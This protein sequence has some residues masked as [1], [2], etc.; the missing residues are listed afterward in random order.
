[1]AIMKPTVS[2][3]SQARCESALLFHISISRRQFV[4]RP[5]AVGECYYNLE[6]RVN[7][8]VT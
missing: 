7:C 5:I 3:I 2:V 8:F 4:C 6:L 1:M